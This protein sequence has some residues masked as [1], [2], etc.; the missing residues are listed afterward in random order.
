M[1]SIT[2]A[3]P[4]AGYWNGNYGVPGV[5]AYGGMGMASPSYG[6]G[7][8]PY[9]NPY[10]GGLGMTGGG[11]DGGASQPAPATPPQGNPAV[12]PTSYNYSQPLDPSAAAPETPPAD[13]ETSPV[14]LARQ[15]FQ[16]GDYDKALGLTQ[17][18]LG[19]MPN[20]VTLHEFLALIYFAQ[21]KYEQAAAPLYAVLSVGPGWDW[22]TLIS[23]YS[24]ASAYTAQIRGLE[25]FVK[26][27]PKSAKAEFVEAYHYISQGHGEAAIKPLKNVVALQPDDKLSAGLLATLQPPD[28]AA[29]APAQAIDPAKLPGVWV[30]QAPQDA[31]ITLTLSDDSHFTWAVALPDKPPVKIEGTYSMAD[32]VL[33]LAGDKAGPL[34]GRIALADDSHL[35][36]KAVGGPSNDPGLNFAR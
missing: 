31:K 29:K 28:D 6:Y 26:A 16:A 36:F 20:D 3:W 12:T 19:Q 23:N 14:A 1:T 33:T 21:G 4:G 13:P 17:Q 35:N 24:D 9:V 7:S 10:A 22:T 8:S 27:N 5:A 32:G 25:A 18:A 34:A 2:P 15:A 30:A 11:G